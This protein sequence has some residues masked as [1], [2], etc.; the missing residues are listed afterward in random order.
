MYHINL[1]L[2]ENNIPYYQQIYEAIRAQIRSGELAPDEKLPSSRTLAQ[3]LSVSRST[4][5]NAYDQLLAEGYLESRPRSGYYVAKLDSM[6]VRIARKPERGAGSRSEDFLTEGRYENKDLISALEEQHGFFSTGS[7]GEA[8]PSGSFHGI[9][10]SL[11]GVDER[12]IP[13]ATWKKLTRE[14]LS[15]GEGQLFHSGDPQGEEAFRQAICRYLREAR[16]VRCTAEQVLVGAGSEY[17]LLLLSQLLQD[18]PVV[19]EEY[20]YRQAGRVLSR[21]GRELISVPSDASGL[22]VEHLP[23]ASCLPCLPALIYCMP[24][25]QFPL[26]TVMPVKRRMELLSYASEHGCYILEDDYDSE[27]R[28]RGKPIPALQEMDTSGRVVYMGTFSRSIAPSI[29][30]SY[31]VLPPQLLEKYRREL[32]FYSST[33]S[34][35]DQMVLTKFLEG[36][37]FERHLNKMRKIYREK[38]DLMV[39]GLSGFSLSGEMAGV[40]L[41][42]T[43]RKG[44]S[45]EELIQRA[46]EAGVKVYGISAYRVPTEKENSRE[47]V[48]GPEKDTGEKGGNGRDV[49]HVEGLLPARVLLGYAGV[50]MDEIRQGTER[51]RKAWG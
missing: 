7:V 48:Y 16:G 4:A 22:M 34:K 23:T 42:V 1:T 44:R 40:H 32:R 12:Y 5:Q 3:N 36:G 18:G 35:I 13:V 19:M 47:K 21:S 11:R 10:F 43:D 6:D 46:E 51:L 39:E 29:R 49:S 38:H 50:P 9:D 30:V 26:G 24:S 27:F 14:A 17:L 15:E 2:E 20:T 28:Y 41:L 8:S 31:L 25:H 37:F 33:V 45:E